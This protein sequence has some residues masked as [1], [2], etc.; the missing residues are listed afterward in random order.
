MTTLKD[1]AEHVGVSIS[2]VSRVL[3]NDTRRAIHSETRQKIWD[4]ATLLGYQTDGARDSSRK[5]KAKKTAVAKVG[6]I[7]AVPQNKYNHPY[8]S[9]ILEGIEQGLSDHGCELAYIHTGDD[10]KKPGMLQKVIFESQINGLILVEGVDESTYDYIRKHVPN[11]VGIDIS[12]EKVPRVGYDRL[13][14]AKH[15][16]RHL[17]ER[18]HEKIG[19]IGGPGLS[20]IMEKEK[21]FRGFREAM[22]EAGVSIGKNWVLDTGWD[23]EKSYEMMKQVLEG[24]GDIPTAFFAASD[25]MAISA[26]RAVHELG[27]RIPQDVAFASID[28]IEV[29][30]YSSPPLT[31]IHMPKFEIGWV[32]SKMLSDYMNGHYPLPVKITVPFE[33]MVRGSS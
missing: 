4:A 17:I 18:G 5:G 6:C 32:A 10:L 29:S 22:E 28:N 12:D 9:P 21:R 13:T 24:E 7:V 2:T 15:A 3:N 27:L 8:F 33:L 30:Q 31:T 20:M 25:M 14:A 26:M 19:Y 16:V 23:V 1:I 11:L